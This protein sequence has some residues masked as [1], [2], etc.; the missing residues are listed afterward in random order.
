M[1]AIAAYEREL[2]A[3]M[4][5]A[6][7]RVPGTTVHGAADRARLDERVPTFCFTI[8]GT[9]PAALATALADRGIAVR[10]GHMYSPRV[11]TRL[12]LMPSGALR[13]SLV[14]YNTLVEIRVFAEVLARAGRN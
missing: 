9:D 13:A 3:A 7:E 11:M 1:E 2:S 12:G 10:S 5:D 6:L 14:H 8:A 4:L